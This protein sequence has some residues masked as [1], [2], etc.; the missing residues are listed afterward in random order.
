MLN[1]YWSGRLVL[2]LFGGLRVHG[3]VDDVE[4]DEAPLLLV[5][6]RF[7]AGRVRVEEARLAVSARVGLVLFQFFCERLF[8]IE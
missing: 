7:V 6:R 3:V 1:I 5:A 4:V 8:K 2:Y